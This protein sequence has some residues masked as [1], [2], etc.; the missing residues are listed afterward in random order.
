MA[1]GD[2]LTKV[3]HEAYKELVHKEHEML[4]QE[5]N[6]QNERLALLE[7][8]ME[9]IKDLTISINQLATNMQHMLEELKTQGKRLESLEAKDGDMWRSLIKGAIGVVA[10]L[11]IGFIFGK[12]LT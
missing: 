2:Y 4:V 3:E 5:N 7:S 10:S 9:G 12:L 8:K 1:D 11:V 6:R